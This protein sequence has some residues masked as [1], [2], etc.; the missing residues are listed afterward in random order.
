MKRLAA[1]V[2]ILMMISGSIAVAENYQAMSD[3]ELLAIL[4][5]VRAEL[6]VRN[7]SLSADEVLMENE[8]VKVYIDKSKNVEFSGNDYLRVKIPLVLV[9]N[10][11]NEISF[12]VESVMVN[13]WECGG[14]IGNV[15][16][17]GKKREILNINCKGAEIT[18]A[19]EIED[20]QL[21]LLAFNMNTYKRELVSDKI[22]I[23]VE[24]GQI[25]KK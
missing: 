25:I 9:S 24:N 7:L 17:A 11:E 20:I 3:E 10:S 19:E 22:T 1:L 12:Q 15:S 18:S 6:L 8:V 13:G 16:T 21:V 14:S 4:H 2:I 23:V 5:A